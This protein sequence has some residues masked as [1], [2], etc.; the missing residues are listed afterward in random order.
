MK[1]TRKASDKDVINQL[2]AFYRLRDLDG[3]YLVIEES[4]SLSALR[5]H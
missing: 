3:F 5:F 4:E 2:V 1:I